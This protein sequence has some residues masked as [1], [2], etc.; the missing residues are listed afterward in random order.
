MLERIVAQ[1]AVA[2]LAW[3]DKRIERQST[4]VDADIDPARLR[5]A[6]DRISEWLRRNEDRIR[7]R[8]ES[9]ADRP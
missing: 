3:L 8:G 5:R 2:M 6:G 9:D 1:V 4:A 7:P